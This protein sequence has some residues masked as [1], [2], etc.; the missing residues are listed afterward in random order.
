MGSAVWLY[1]FLLISANRNDGT[2]LRRQETIAAQ[3]G[4]NERTVERW[5]QILRENG[6]ITS[7][8]NGRSLRIRITKWRPIKGGLPPPKQN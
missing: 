1:L 8:S 5:L 3:T 4:F 2:V 7:T 6:Y